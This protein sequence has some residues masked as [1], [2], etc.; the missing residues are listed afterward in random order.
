MRASRSKAFSLVE[1]LVVIGIIAVLTGLVAFSFSGSTDGMQLTQASE[2][3]RGEFDIARST[4][5]A[6]NRNVA[7]CF[8]RLANDAGPT[9][10]AL[11][12]FMWNDADEAWEPLRPARL[13]PEGIIIADI[14]EHATLP[15]R[16]PM[17]DDP[18]ADPVPPPTLTAIGVDDSRC[19]LFRPNG[20]TD[21]DPT[22]N[23]FLTLYAER[24]PKTGSGL[25]DNWATVRLQPTLG[26]AQILRP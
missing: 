4:A 14:A 20:G 19:F 8:Y 13:L 12:L 6:Q 5:L 22:E 21:L 7:V 9:W 11:G 3:V 24:A 25:P 17:S 10:R 26:R 2:R 15:H 16:L 18:D 23:W 1:L